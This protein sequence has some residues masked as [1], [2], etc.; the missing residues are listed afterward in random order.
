M[1]SGNWTQDYEKKKFFILNSSREVIRNQSGLDIIIGA[2]VHKTGGVESQCWGY[3]PPE[4]DHCPYCGETLSEAE[5]LNESWIPPYG[6]GDGLR[7]VAGSIDINQ[8]PIK[9][10]ADDRSKIFIEQEEEAFHL[11]DRCGSYEFI[12]AKLG[13][14]SAVLVAF[15]RNSGRIDYYCFAESRWYSFSGPSIEESKLPHWSWSA[16]VV[17]GDSGFAIPSE[18]GPV[19]IAL[20][21]ENCSS[22]PVRGQGEA[23]GGAAVLN[24][25]IFIPTIFEGDLIIQT[26]AR[27]SSE[28]KQTGEAISKNVFGRDVCKSADD[29]PEDNYF[30]VPIVDT[31]KAFIYWVGVNGLLSFDTTNIKTS[32]RPWETDANPCRAVPE[33]GPPYHDNHGNFW[34][35]CFDEFDNSTGVQGYRYYKLG[36]N[37]SDRYDVLGPRF[38]SGI[39]CFGR[40]HDLWGLPWDMA[41]EREK[42][43]SEIRFP[44]VCINTEESKPTLVAKFRENIEIGLEQICQNDVSRT[45]ELWIEAKNKTPILLR[46]AEPLTTSSPL[47]LR[48]FVCNDKLYLYSPEKVCC[49]LW[50]LK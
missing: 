10:E 40:L 31:R 45:T 23:V 41:G 33:L 3:F 50:S 37:E 7:L 15:C 42:G 26:F 1:Q 28:W 8:L 2:K 39:S 4:F 48:V 21:W 35:I 34:Q 6:K 16:G 43:H 18:K 32:W 25:S 30:S 13:T 19:W 38:S 46:T 29:R 5:I 14:K 11:P 22:K 20:D 27:K 17:N 12:V 49:Y 47:E 9:V 44:L 36:G 24:T